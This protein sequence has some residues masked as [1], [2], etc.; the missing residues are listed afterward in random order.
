VNDRKRVNTKKIVIVGGVAGGASAATAARRLSEDAE[1]V[2]IERGAFVSF[3]NCG[4]PY[5]LGGE[6]EDQEELSVKTP[7]GLLARYNLDVRVNS[8]VV[9][10]DRERRQVEVETFGGEKYV[11]S[12]DALI[13]STGASPLVPAGIPG[14]GRA[15]H[16][17]LRTI[18][19]M[20]AIDAWIKSKN[21][22]SAVVVGGGFIGLEMAEQLHRRG[23]SVTLAEAAVQ[24]MT[25][26][27]PEMAAWLEMEL[28]NQGVGLHL[29]DAVAAFEEP[30]QGEE[31]EASTVVLKSG[32][33]I[34]AD[35]VVLGLGVRPESALARAAGLEVGERGGIRVDD[36]LRTSVP[37][38]WAIGDCIEVKDGVTGAPALIPLAG[39]ANRQGRIAAINIFG[40][41]RK[42]P[43]S[44]GT[45]IVRAFGLAAG[46]TGASENALRERGM[47]FEA[48]HLHPYSHADYYPGASRLALKVI[49]DPESGRLLGAQAVGESGV[50]KRIDVLATALRAGM[51]VSDLV[52]LELA[53]APPFGSAKDP[54]NLAGMV[55]EHVLG[56]EILPAQWR[57]VA[58][59][60]G[61]TTVILDVR[62]VKEREAGHIPASLHIPLDELR[63][64]MSELPRDREILCYCQ[65]GQRSYMACRALSQRGYRVRN[66]M[67]SYRTWQAAGNHRNR[68]SSEPLENALKDP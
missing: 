17:T 22:R 14:I 39:P 67:G 30:G 28:V 4:L 2:L 7:A 50:D 32:A 35:L 13:L 56:G 64:R 59:L 12:Y 31:A 63:A 8:T 24:V 43:A 37:N 60:D 61:K 33:R 23:L 49:F 25:S 3:A 58:G 21:A 36:E 16:F 51:T 11:E 55:A 46:R 48:I 29:G 15:G 45:A 38:I 44:L 65:T 42:N 47:P 68:F 53:Y 18:P 5:W 27:D 6:I 54:V 52:D 34:P 26:F 9:A 19:D 40:G 66:L 10:I 62:S 20:L 41:G 1:I 57:D